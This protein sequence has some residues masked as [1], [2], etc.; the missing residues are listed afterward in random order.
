MRR[1]IVA[2]VTAAL[3]VVAAAPAAQAEGRDVAA[4]GGVRGAVC[5]PPF[6]N[7]CTPHGRFAFWATS[8]PVG[9]DA[10][11]FA[12]FESLGPVESQSQGRVTC[13]NVAGNLASVG[14]IVERGEGVAEEFEGTPF[15]FWV[16]DGDVD[17]QGSGPDLFSLHY[18]NAV[19]T[20]ELG[21]FG[22][23]PPEFPNVCPPPVF[24]LYAPV[25]PGNIVVR[26]ALVDPQ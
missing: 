17:G 9:L 11:G 6:G 13:L 21:F 12:R 10:H 15:V 23:L 8:D 19:P 24:A 3:T 25:E 4:G 1:L 5:F 2:A 26:D 14:G 20:R 16:V 7:P 22:F 18:I